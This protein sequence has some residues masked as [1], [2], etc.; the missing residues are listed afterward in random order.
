MSSEFGNLGDEFGNLEDEFQDQTF[1]IDDYDG[2]EDVEISMSEDNLEDQ[3][4]TQGDFERLAGEIRREDDE[5]KSFMVALNYSEI[6]LDDHI[7][8]SIEKYVDTNFTPEELGLHHNET[9]IVSLVWKFENQKLTSANYLRFVDRF[10]GIGK[11]SER[12]IRLKNEISSKI[13]K[14]KGQ[15]LKRLKQELKD[16]DPKSRINAVDL[17]R[18]IRKFNNVSLTI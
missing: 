18:Y 7:K 1:E 13:L 8:K 11:P 3:V 16:L 17:L 15:D 14:A 9:L 12:V 5:Y 10:A 2:Y 6:S 4:L